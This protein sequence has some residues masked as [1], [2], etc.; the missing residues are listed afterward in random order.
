MCSGNWN[1]QINLN[2]GRRLIFCTAIFLSPDDIAQPLRLS[3]MGEK[4]LLMIG[5]IKNRIEKLQT[6]FPTACKLLL[7]L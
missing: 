3:F 4:M 5:G 1:A 6:K 2:R 7:I